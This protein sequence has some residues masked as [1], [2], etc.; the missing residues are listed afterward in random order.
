MKRRTSL[1]GSHP[2]SLLKGS[3]NG[4]ADHTS[5]SSDSKAKHMGRWTQSPPSVLHSPP[6]IGGWKPR[7]PPGR[8]EGHRKDHRRQPEGESESNFQRVHD[9]GFVM[10][11]KRLYMTATPR[12][13]GDR[14]K[15]RANETGSPR[16][17]WATNRCTGQSSI[18]S[19]STSH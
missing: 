5:G 12:I 15:G 19:A 9:N 6:H 16:P 4:A 11:R 2:E 10:A 3:V 7:K 13:Y 8:Q 14:A 1:L 17:P 18:A